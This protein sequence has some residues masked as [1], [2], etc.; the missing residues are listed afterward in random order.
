MILDLASS[1]LGTSIVDVTDE[2]F[3]PAIMMINP[4]PAI[5]CPD[6]FV[7]KK[8]IKLLSVIFVYICLFFRYRSLDGR[9]GVQTS[10]SYL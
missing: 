5:S 4:E 2:F 10:Q 7:G 8:K 3:A 9:V 1:G 6:R